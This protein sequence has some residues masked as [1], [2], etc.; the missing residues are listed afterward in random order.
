MLMPLRELVGAMDQRER[1]PQIEVAVGSKTTALVLRHLEPRS[2]PGSRPAARVRGRAPH[3]V[4]VAAQGPD[5]VHPMEPGERLDHTLPGVPGV[6]MPFKPTD[7]TQVNHQINRVLVDRAWCLLKVGREE[8]VAST[9]SVAWATPPAAGQRKPER[10]WA[11]RAARPGGALARECR[12]Q[13]FG[14][15]AQVCGPATCSRSP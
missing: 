9:G 11:S 12:G 2:R 1:I 10:C 5:T 8:R 4:V 15:S 6:V 7:F 13:R 3:P 14:W